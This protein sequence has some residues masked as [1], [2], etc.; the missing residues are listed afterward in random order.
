MT[1]GR[2][3]KLSTV[4]TQPEKNEQVETY[5]DDES[6]Y[7]EDEE[8]ESESDRR[9]EEEEGDEESYS[10]NDESS[11]NS[12]IEEAKQKKIIFVQKYANSLLMFIRDK[13]VVK[14]NYKGEILDQNV[15]LKKSNIKKLILHAISKKAE[16]PVGYKFFYNLLKNF[17]IP[18]YLLINNLKKYTSNEEL[19]PWRPPGELYK[20]E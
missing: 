18:N 3:M 10:E 6:Q 13:N 1:T 7:A 4:D 17:K 16:K 8:E 14:W 15:P 9:E 11:Y 2:G 19:S 20:K 12:S 5:S